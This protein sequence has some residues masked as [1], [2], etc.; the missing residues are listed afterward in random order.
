MGI[1]RTLANDRL[2][3]DR[4]RYPGRRVRAGGRLSAPTKQRG[5]LNKVEHGVQRHLGIDPNRRPC[6][7]RV[8]VWC[9]WF[10]FGGR[11]R[12]RFAMIGTLSVFKVMVSL[13]PGLSWTD[14]VPGSS[15]RPRKPAGGSLAGPYGR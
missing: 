8:S 15:S 7:A 14:E 13:P 12:C 3:H 9:R 5:S 2:H 6:Q 11:H 4:R 1:G 10:G